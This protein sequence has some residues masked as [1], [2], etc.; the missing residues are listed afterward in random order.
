ML[1]LAFK[2]PLSLAW[3][4][5][6]KRCKVIKF[7]KH[8]DSQRKNFVRPIADPKVLKIRP[9]IDPLINSARLIGADKERRSNG[10]AKSDVDPIA[11]WRSAS[12]QSRGVG[13]R[14]RESR[15]RVRVIAECLALIGALEPC[16]AIAIVPLQC[17]SVT[18]DGRGRD[19]LI[20][21]VIVTP[22]R[23]VVAARGWRPPTGESYRESSR[24]S[25]N[26][27]PSL[28]P[29]PRPPLSFLYR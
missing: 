20:V 25:R 5:V 15:R 16:V 17:R 24:G 7:A 19:A 23:A 28:P 21:H 3:F 11:S 2:S 26:F 6:N 14:G 27:P 22:P 4:I 9:A 10:P 8:L 1:Y 13:R 12:D 18:P 29:F